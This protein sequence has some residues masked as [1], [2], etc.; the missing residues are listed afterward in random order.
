MKQMKMLGRFGF[1]FQVMTNYRKIGFGVDISVS[2][3]HP[4]GTAYI[5]RTSLMFY[6]ALFVIAELEK[7]EE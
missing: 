5:F 6:D 1:D 4:S 7:E 3:M 2:P